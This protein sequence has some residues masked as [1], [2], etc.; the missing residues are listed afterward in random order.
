MAQFYT[1]FSNYTDASF[2]ADWVVWSAAPSTIW[3]LTIEDVSGATGG[4]VGR[5]ARPESQSPRFETVRRKV[6]IDASTGPTDILF[7]V[8][9][10]RNGLTSGDDSNTVLFDIGFRGSINGSDQRTAYALSIRW[11][12]QAIL[13]ARVNNTWTG[14]LAVTNTNFAGWPQFSFSPWIWIRIQADGNT[15]RWRWWENTEPD[16]WTASVTDSQIASGDAVVIDVTNTVTREFDVF[17]VGTNGD[18]APTSPIITGPE[19]TSTTKLQQAQSLTI[20]GSSFGSAAGD[21]GIVV[22]SPTDDI[23]GEGA[24]TQEVSSWSATSL[25]IGSVALPSGHSPGN[26]AYLFV[27]NDALEENEAGYEIKIADFALRVNETIRDTDSGGVVNETVEAVVIRGSAGN[28]EVLFVK[29]GAPISSGVLEMTD[30]TLTVQ[31]YNQ[32]K[33]VAL[34]GSGNRMALLPATVV[35]RNDD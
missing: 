27:R 20:T 34:I 15:L 21:N 1:D 29:P 26:T 24:V 3:N 12:E 13:F 16:T 35:D 31:N 30:S 25:T 9:A 19:I 33:H 28:R 2:A 22:I 10:H 17:A 5:F 8:R 11:S 18:P 7:R 32:T 4:K 14:N 6:P 23:D